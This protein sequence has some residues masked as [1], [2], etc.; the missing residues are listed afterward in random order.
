M[1]K[2]YDRPIVIQVQNRKTETWSDLYHVHARINKASNDNEYLGS[3]ASQSKR[4][5]VFEFRY[6]HQ[7]EAVDRER[8]YYRIVYQGVPYAIEDFDDYMLRH[9]TVKVLGVSY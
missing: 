3:G 8:Q 9:K 7:L 5:Y 6:F 1:G 2:T 4:N